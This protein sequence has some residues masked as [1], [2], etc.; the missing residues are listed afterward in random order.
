MAKSTRS[1]HG[2]IRV[3]Y[4][5]EADA[6]AVELRRAIGRPTTKEL[7]PDHHADFDTRGRLVA[8][9]ILRAS[10]HY[11]QAALEHLPSPVEWLTLA[12]ASRESGL[13]ADTLRV[14]INKGRLRA[15]K[16]GRDWL[17]AVHELW[18]YLESRAPQ[19]RRSPRERVRARLPGAL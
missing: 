15:V 16:R 5:P 10:R 8:L 1:R 2:G 3:T 4:D 12:E 14:Q 13:A 17:V 11:G 6:L 7:S 18:N 9:E 19:G